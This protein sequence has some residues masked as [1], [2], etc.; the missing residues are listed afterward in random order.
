MAANSVQGLPLG[1]A[2]KANEIARQISGRMLFDIRLDDD[3]HYQRIAGIR[4]TNSEIG[5]LTLSLDGLSVRAFPISR[6]S[7]S[8]IQPLERW[9]SLPLREQ[10]Q[11][12][13]QGAARLFVAVLE[14]RDDG[15]L[16][17]D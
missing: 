3:P 8:L 7:A 10:V 11:T 6:I 14:Y 5:V 1:F 13:I 2:G 12:D 4:Y 15:A 9:A 16:H 17:S